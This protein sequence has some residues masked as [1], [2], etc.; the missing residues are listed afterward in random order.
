MTP[1]G[2]KLPMKV[3]KGQNEK[4]NKNLNVNLMTMPIIIPQREEPSEK[5]NEDDCNEGTVED[6]N[7]NRVKESGPEINHHVFNDDSKETTHNL[8]RD[9]THTQ[10]VTEQSNNIEDNATHTENTSEKEEVENETP[11]ECGNWTGANLETLSQWIQISSLQIE[12]LDIAIKYFRS[13]VRRNVLLGLVFSTASGSIS[14]FQLNSQSQQL[15]LNIIFTIM[16]FSIA[17][18]TGLIKIYQI[19]ERL[20]EFIQIKQEWIGFSVVITAEVQLPVRQRKK[21]IDIIT[22]NKNK[23]LD[24]LKRDLDI[25]N[26]I[27]SRAYKNLYHDKYKQE[28]LKNCERHKLLKEIWACAD[29]TYFQ[30]AYEKM[31]DGDIL[32]YLDA[33]CYINPYGFK[34]FNEYIEMLKNSEEACISFQ[35]PQHIEKKWTTKEIFEYL[36][37]HSD[38]R[39]ITETGQIIA[40]VRMFKKNSNRNSSNLI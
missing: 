20:E 1:T 28:Y 10:N 36:N 11:N 2:T 32:I 22:K 23:Y 38:S 15:F 34:R 30:K 19:Q 8:Q 27:K 13:I 25:P 35:M 7:E 18:F 4:N 16:S 26:F 31:E 5:T 12:I 40:T 33:G 14:V 37:I 29:D 9:E 6:T 21:A 24:L 17:I 39:D 3:M